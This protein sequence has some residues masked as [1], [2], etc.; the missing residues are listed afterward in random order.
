ML[1]L[2][3]ASGARHDFVDA[4]KA[5]VAFSEDSYGVKYHIENQPAESIGE[6]RSGKWIAYAARTLIIRFWELA[7]VGPTVMRIQNKC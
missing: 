4:L 7:K 1:T 6:M 5:K 2:S 3:F